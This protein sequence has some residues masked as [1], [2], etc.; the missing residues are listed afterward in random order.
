MSDGRAKKKLKRW[1]GK[2]GHECVCRCGVQVW[3]AWHGKGWGVEG[4]GSFLN[5]CICMCMQGVMGV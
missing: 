3:C 4:S 1:V 2:V 5:I